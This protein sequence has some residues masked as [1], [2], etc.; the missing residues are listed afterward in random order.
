[1]LDIPSIAGIVA[2]IG[3]IIG[4]I[5]TIEEL[6]ALVKTR[7]T[8]LVVRLYSTFGSKEFQKAAW[9]VSTLEFKDYNDFVEK[10]GP[11]TNIEAWSTWNSLAA[12]FEGVGVLAKRKL[13]AMNLVDDMMSSGIVLLW[14]QMGP[15]VEEMRKQYERPQIWEWFEYLY[16]EMQK[17]EQRLQQ[18]QQ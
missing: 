18:T 8:D 7:Q 17:R 6:R 3:V 2:A 15:I 16:N 11:E 9:T 14:E 1:M 10:Y 5:F 13:I 12:F 4:V